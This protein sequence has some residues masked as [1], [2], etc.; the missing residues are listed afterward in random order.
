MT[1]KII[2][3]LVVFV[4]A[5]AGVYPAHAAP[6]AQTNPYLT[7]T[8]VTRAPDAIGV[9][10]EEVTCVE[11]PE[12]GG[13]RCDFV[14][15]VVS[16]NQYTVGRLFENLQFT[17]SRGAGV[18]TYYTYAN[19]VANGGYWYAGPTINLFSTTVSGNPFADGNS[20][21]YGN[22][23]V[24]V[25]GTNTRNT[26]AAVSFGLQVGG[27]GSNG[28]VGTFVFAPMPIDTC[29]EN[30]TLL[31][32]DSYEID[33]VIEIPLGPSGDPADDQI[34]PT[35]L[36]QV[37]KISTSG[38]PWNDGTD[39]HDDLAV[40]WDGVTWTPLSA[41]PS[42]CQTQGTGGTV[43][44]YYIIAESETF[45][46]RVNDTEGDFADNYNN[47]DPMIYT[48]GLTTTSTSE[49]ESQYTYDPFEDVVGFTGVPATSEA[50]VLANNADIPLVVGEWYVVQWDTGYWQDDGGPDQIDLEYWD[51]NSNQWLDL[52]AGSSMVWCVSTD[53]FDVLIQAH[54]VE[55]FLRVNNVTG[56]FSSNTGTPYYTLYQVAFTRTP[57]NC[58]GTIQV[59][60]LI[61]HRIVEADQSGGQVFASM[62]GGTLGSIGL[63][64]GEYYVVDTTDGPWWQ[65]ATNPNYRY[66]MAVSENNGS[67]WEQLE[68]WNTPECNIPL[69]TL[70]HRRVIFQMPSAGEVYY[71][72]RVDGSG[73]FSFNQGSMEWDLYG[74]T[75]L[76]NQAGINTCDYTYNA[77][78]PVV[79]G[80]VEGTNETGV[81]L[82]G[83]VAGEMYAVHIIGDG[84]GWRES[85]ID[86]LRYDVEMS[87]NGG[88][89][90]ADMP[91]AYAPKLCY[92][93]DGNNLLVYIYAQQGYT[94]KL[95][96]NSTSYGNNTGDM[97]YAVYP[98]TPGQSIINTCLDGWSLQILN[99]FDWLDVR[100]EDGE[101]LSADT[102]RYE[103]FIALVPGRSYL[104]ETPAGQGPWKS[105]D[106][107]STLRWDTALSPDNGTTWEPISYDSIFINCAGYNEIDHTWRARFT[108]QEGEVWK[109]RVNDTAGNFANNTGNMAYKFYVLCEGMAC[110][111]SI[112]NDDIPAVSIQ[113]GGDVCALAL[114]RPDSLID[115]GGWIQYLNLS[116]LRYMAWCPRHTNILMEFLN[117]FRE[118]EPLASITE[119]DQQV[120]EV[121]QEIESYDW[122][123]NGNQSESLFD[124]TTEGELKTKVIDPLT[125]NGDGRSIW[126]GGI[127]VDFTDTGFPPAYYSCSSVFVNSLPSGLRSGVCFVSAY[128]IETSAS[129]W[130]QLAVDISAFF[131]L[132][133]M[134]KG[135]VQELVY[136]MTGVKPWTAKGSDLYPYIRG[137]RDL[138]YQTRDYSRGRRR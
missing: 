27:N 21:S 95:R 96:V 90:W 138:P 53:G 101:V 33:P 81:T 24:E 62:V 127:A 48:I 50:G 6:N 35:V 61:E 44:A 136:M 39:D 70:G 71:K 121:K 13:I 36:N 110:T 26:T 134:I 10:R 11:V 83:L 4:F 64:A 88:Y 25:F 19:V 45:Y 125:G 82:S 126:E 31:T 38:G 49:C 93:Q 58:E 87:N 42:E 69:D 30:Y 78:S 1:K 57:S 135:A 28:F 73:I 51:N 77:A 120:Q 3:V 100:D 98:A 89:L 80:V 72:F 129:F 112:P 32:E 106:D 85:A 29:T 132:L 79:T 20:P 123:E 56:T 118:R 75:K 37:Y 122:G 84:H 52:A 115:I 9:S 102:A 16:P 128:F 43:D 104:V 18:Y 94:Y 66:D 59:D 34:Y 46:I 91:T 130:I 92:E 117:K 76:Q 111:G 114:V 133:G 15:A 86:S 60:E 23:D 40:S 97:G 119:M 14:L 124:I 41:Y 107:L 74:A 2:S 67:T 105:F 63:T 99:E 109:I 8:S 65:L 22:G 103:E 54:D 17:D 55:L 137:E 5:W 116:V 113:G 68:N 131:L 108:V 7:I 47:P 12:I